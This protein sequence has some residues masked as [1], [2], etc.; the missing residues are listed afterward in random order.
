MRNE[1]GDASGWGRRVV[2]SK[3]DDL[4]NWEFDSEKANPDIIESPRMLR[5]GDDLYLIGRTDPSGH[6]MNNKL[7]QRILP[8]WLHHL[9]DLGW[10]SVRNHGNAIWKVNK[11]KLSLEK[12]ADLPGCGDTSFASIIRLTKNRF[13]IAN[14]S[15]PRD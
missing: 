3:A 15:S 10:Y 6:F 12:V 9:I 4:A 14:Y 1:D 8:S 11:S 2:H 7:W 5:H 13:L